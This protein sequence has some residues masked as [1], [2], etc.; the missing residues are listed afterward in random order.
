MEITLVGRQP[1]QGMDRGVKHF[2]G[3]GSVGWEQRENNTFPHLVTD[4]VKLMG[5]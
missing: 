5:E 2:A 3:R 4:F 1:G